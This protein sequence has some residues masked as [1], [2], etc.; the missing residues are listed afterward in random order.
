MCVCVCVSVCVCAC[1]CV[2]VCSAVREGY[3]VL[4]PGQTCDVIQCNGGLCQ[5]KRKQYYL[6]QDW[7]ISTRIGNR[8]YPP[9]AFGFLSLFSLCFFF[10][11]FFL[12]FLYVHFSILSLF[13]VSSFFFFSFLSFFSFFLS[14]L[15]IF[16]LSFFPSCLPLPPPPFF[17]Q[18]PYMF[19]S[20]SFFLSFFLSYFRSFV[21]SFSQSFFLSVFLCFFPSFLSTS[22]S[23]VKCY[24]TYNIILY[25]CEHVLF[26]LLYEIVTRSISYIKAQ[27]KKCS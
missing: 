23:S 9:F 6:C 25:S 5:V 4:I 24:F 3:M 16:F 27:P 14:F 21:R 20:S 13:L 19:R 12:H 11:F 10:F 26:I 18:C 1:V 22:V 7:I 2:C 17:F 15:I 8:L